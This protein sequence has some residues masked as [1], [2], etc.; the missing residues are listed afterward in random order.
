MPVDPLETNWYY[1][2]ICEEVLDLNVGHLGHV[3]F[4]KGLK[5]WARIEL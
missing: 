3:G 5:P 4:L 2:R 1:S